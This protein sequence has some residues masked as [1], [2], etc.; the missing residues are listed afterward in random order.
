MSDQKLTP[1]Q[2]VEVLHS[3]KR[4]SIESGELDTWF[5]NSYLNLPESIMSFIPG[6]FTYELLLLI[7]GYLLEDNND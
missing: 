3:I 7:E 4:L 6:S 2:I 5:E 1:E